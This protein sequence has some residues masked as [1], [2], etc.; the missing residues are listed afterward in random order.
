MLANKLIGTFSFVSS[1][2]FVGGNAL[3]IFP[4]ETTL[5]IPL[6]GLSGGLDSA[7]S[8]GDVVIVCVGFKS[9]VDRTLSSDTY[10]KLADLKAEGGEEDA[11]LGVFYKRLTDVE[12]STVIT[13]NVSPNVSMRCAIHV[14]RNVDAT[15]PIDVTTTTAIGDVGVPNSPPITP[16]S[17]GAVVIAVGSAAYGDEEGV[18]LTVPS[19]MTN[20]F[21]AQ[22]NSNSG[23][24][25]AS[26]L[27]GTAQE[28]DPPSFGGGSL[29]DMNS[30][31]AVSVALRPE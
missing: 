6:T 31:C 20:F 26:V 19:G 21:T 15:N 2:E 27:T 18:A 16:V 8:I 22:T 5:T 17:N 13:F 3:T 23:I 30:F 28:Y 4:S 7:P 12:T 25:I 11:Q 24:A 14:W 1:L 9:S 29:D 10:T